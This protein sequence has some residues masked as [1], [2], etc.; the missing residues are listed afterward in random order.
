LKNFGHNRVEEYFTQAMEHA[1]S[2]QEMYALSN[3]Y[4]Q[5]LA[6]EL[7]RIR[8]ALQTLRTT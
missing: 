8:E 6:V 7:K 5:L 3:A 4:E 2:D 1:E